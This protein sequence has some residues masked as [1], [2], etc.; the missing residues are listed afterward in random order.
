MKTPQ[1]PTPEFLQR[2]PADPYYAAWVAPLRLRL[3]GTSATGI[4]G[5]AMALG[6][7]RG[8]EPRIK[9]FIGKASR[10]R[11]RMA[12]KTLAKNPTFRRLG[13]QWEWVERAGLP[14]DAIEVEFFLPL[15]NFPDV[16][17]DDRGARAG[18]PRATK[19]KP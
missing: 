5:E 12:G 1:P 13:L 2:R 10:H 19:A 3:C 18:G 11:A 14:A 4:I 7:E 9:L 15:Q 6:E 8:L 16:I 17:Y